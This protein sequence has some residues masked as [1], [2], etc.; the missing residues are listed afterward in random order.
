MTPV[1]VRAPK[2][3]RKEGNYKAKPDRKTANKF[4][5]KFSWIDMFILGEGGGPIYSGAD[6]PA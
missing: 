1:H 2:E 6:S 5:N 3:N 4:D